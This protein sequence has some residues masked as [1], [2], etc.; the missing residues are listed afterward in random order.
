MDCVSFT[1][2]LMALYDGII[3]YEDLAADDTQF[4]FGC[5]REHVLQ[6]SVPL[7]TTWRNTERPQ[8]VED[9][10]CTLD[11]IDPDKQ[12]HWLRYLAVIMRAEREG[13][14]IWEIC[15]DTMF[16]G[17]YEYAKALDEAGKDVFPKKYINFGR[18]AETY[19]ILLGDG[20]ADPIR[21]LETLEKKYGS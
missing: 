1:S 4:H 16:G 13:R 3:S 7:E 11:D 18:D 17:Y 8:V 5:S 15:Q 12:Q 14:I 20:F 10:R 6:E 2:T 9:R 19:E 21:T